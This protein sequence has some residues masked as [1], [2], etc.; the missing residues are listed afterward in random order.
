MN[1]LSQLPIM[2]LTIKLNQ[3]KKE[4]VNYMSNECKMHVELC[5]KIPLIFVA[6]G[7]SGIMAIP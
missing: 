5:L 1:K 7:Y 3:P 2:T 6:R 4:L